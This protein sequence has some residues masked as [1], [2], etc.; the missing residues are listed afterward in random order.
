MGN[1]LLGCE[2]YRL[3]DATSVNY[4][5][6]SVWCWTQWP[7]TI[8]TFGW[9]NFYCAMLAEGIYAEFHSIA[10]CAA[11]K[12]GFNEFRFERD[13]KKKVSDMVGDH[14]RRFHK[15]YH[16]ATFEKIP[17]ELCRYRVSN[18][19]IHSF[20]CLDHEI[21]QF[22]PDELEMFAVVFCDRDSRVNH[23]ILQTFFLST[24]CHS[25]IPIVDHPTV[26]KKLH[27]TQQYLLI[28]FL[29]AYCFL[30]CLHWATKCAVSQLAS[31]WKKG[32]I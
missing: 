6:W 9:R 28:N 11:R 30:L 7:L 31:A 5:K 19:S 27:W 14:L 3:D 32:I 24:F 21:G 4:C 12:I 29:F 10:R 2:P 23:K 15:F 20:S 13:F 26:S 25:L 8:K 1:K 16:W 18:N 17:V 22:P